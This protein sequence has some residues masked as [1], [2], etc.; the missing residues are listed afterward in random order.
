MSLK[1]KQ[2]TK[3]N[4]IFNNPLSNVKSEKEK[5]IKNDQKQTSSKEP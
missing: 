1:E 3:K 5:Q 4:N 2:I